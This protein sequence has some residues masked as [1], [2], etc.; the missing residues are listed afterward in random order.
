MC[1][2][3]HSELCAA[4]TR[5]GGHQAPLRFLALVMGPVLGPA[6]AGRSSAAASACTIAIASRPAASW[7]GWAAS[8]ASG[9][10]AAFLLPDVGLKRRSW[11]KNHSYEEQLVIRLYIMPPFICW[12]RR[13]AACDSL[14]SLLLVLQVQCLSQELLLKCWWYDLKDLRPQQHVAPH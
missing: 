8:K 1:M 14:P 4:G 5:K 11:Q 10:P 3:V 6:A 13:A 9:A 2:I 7:F 12:Q